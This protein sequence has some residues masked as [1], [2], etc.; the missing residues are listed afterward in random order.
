MQIMVS[1]TGSIM[2]CLRAQHQGPD[3]LGLYSVSSSFTVYLLVGSVPGE[4]LMT[5]GHGHEILAHPDIGILQQIL[6]T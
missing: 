3:Y 1:I 5:L 2:Q 6:L 4:K